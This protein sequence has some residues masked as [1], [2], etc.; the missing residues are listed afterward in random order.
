MISL[1]YNRCKFIQCFLSFLIS[2]KKLHGAQHFLKNPVLYNYLNYV[3][4]KVHLEKQRSFKG[5][6]K[7]KT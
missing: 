4:V 5:C 1:E 2:V 7:S 6:F 3:G